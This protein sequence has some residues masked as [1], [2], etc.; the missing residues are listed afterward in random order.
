MASTA[1][2]AGQVVEVAPG[3]HRARW[4]MAAGALI[5]DEQERVLLVNPTYHADRWLMPG[6]G[7]EPIGESPRA[8]CAREVAEELGVPWLVGALLVTDWIPQDGRFFEEVVFVFDAGVMDEQTRNRIRVP[9]KELA[10]FAFLEPEEAASRLAAP[11]ARRMLA[12][13][14]ARRRGGGAVYLEYGNPAPAAAADL[15]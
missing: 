14:D 10:G 5:T 11:D 2:A 3:Y 7:M 4:P 13:L 8:A 1:A 15:P 9:P 12:A 6:G